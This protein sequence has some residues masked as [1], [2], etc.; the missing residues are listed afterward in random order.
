MH[1]YIEKLPI[2]IRRD[3]GD[4]RVMTPAEVQEFRSVLA[5]VRWPVARL[6][7]QLA[8]GVSALSHKDSSEK[9]VLH[10]RALNELIDRLKGYDKQGLA[11]LRLRKLNIENLMVLTLMGASF[12]KEAG[13]KSQMGS[14]NMLTGIGIQTGPETCDL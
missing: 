4:T 5:K 10:I 8:Y 7:P 12:A 3:E 11:T 9:Q 6:V 2:R 13:C 14:M 1:E